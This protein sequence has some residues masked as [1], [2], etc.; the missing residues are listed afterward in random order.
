M[1]E[2]SR[3]ENQSDELKAEMLI[4]NFDK[5]YKIAAEHGISKNKI[6]N[7]ASMVYEELIKKEEFKNAYTIANEYSMDESKLDIAASRE[8]RKLIANGLIDDAIEWGKKTK[9]IKEFEI[10][11][12]TIR[13]F[14]NL[15]KKNK[16]RKALKL[17]DKYKIPTSQVMDDAMYYYNKSFKINDFL[18]A[19]ILGKKFN[20]SEKR[21]YTA[22]VRVLKKVIAS[23]DVEKIIYINKEF[24]IFTDQVFDVIDPNDSS[25]L[26]SEFA[27]IIEEYLNKYDIDKVINI[28]SQIDILSGKYKNQFLADMVESIYQKIGLSH[29]RLLKMEMREKAT[30]LKDEFDLIEKDVPYETKK[31]VIDGAQNFHNSLLDNYDYEAAKSIKDEYKLFGKN[32]I[33]NSVEVSLQVSS[34]YLAKTF[35]RGEFDRSNRVIEDYDIPKEKVIEIAKKIILGK[36]NAE[37]YKNAV[38]ILKRFKI[39]PAEPEFEVN[40]PNVFKDMLNTENYEAAAEIG[41]FFNLDRKE[42]LRAS[43]ISW[44]KKINN[45]DFE[46][47]F[48][49]YKRHKIPNTAIKKTAAEVYKSYLEKNDLKTCKTIR[50]QYKLSIGVFG[51]IVEFIKRIIKYK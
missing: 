41:L 25:I 28:F 35:M 12:I 4:L 43:V 36:L 46:E 5:V 2:L 51:L 9:K 8:F 18:T 37:G 30:M 50:K 17:I 19:A 24:D 10:N 21:T 45:S 39:D 16:P 40:A 15:L 32:A 34:D 14:L 6:S 22:A 44:N 23:K 33:E 42:T 38:E 49:L 1:E 3:K 26:S 31:I 20:F 13:E 7:T 47:A 11:K 29:N 48:L 27:N